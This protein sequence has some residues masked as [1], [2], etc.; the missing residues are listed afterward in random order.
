MISKLFTKSAPFLA[1]LGLAFTGCQPDLE[2]DIK[3]S[4]GTADFSRYIAVG[5]SL[6]A[7][8][9]DGGLYLEGQLT[10]YPNL[11]A[12]QFRSVGGGD[13]TQPLFTEAQRNGSGYI[14][15]TGFTTPAPPATPAPITAPVTSELA[16]RQGATAARPLYTK[17]TEP[18]SNLG[19][20]GIR[21]SDILTPGYGSVQGNP[22]FERITPDAQAT[23]TYLARVAASNPT[24]FTC[25]MGN[26][27]VLGFATAGAAGN[28][29]TPL[30][31][32]TNNNN[33]L[34]DALTAN[35]A[36]GLVATIPDVTNIPF[37]TTVGPSFRATLTTNNV[38]G[39]VITTGGFSS[40]PGTPPVRR[41]IA[42]TAIRDANGNGNQLF[43]LTAS[44]YLA[45]FGR[46]NNGRAWRD[47]Y[48]QARP[49]LPP[50]VTLS[51][52]LLLQ[53]VDTTQA[54]GASA[55]NPIPSTLVLDDTEQAQIRTATT[56][57]NTALTTKATAKNLA[58]FD[59]NG[60]FARVATNGF[61]TNGVNNSA[62][63]ITGNLFSLD[64]VHL[65]PRGYAVVA[66]EMI[67][68]INQQYGASVPNINPND[69]RGVRFP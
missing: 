32:F 34:I 8:F 5:N 61:V 19:V 50:T 39:V 3:P 55:G 54:F 31:T 17:F 66:N 26:N 42:T 64:G 41:T 13:F 35:N 65:T 47:V 18:V 1:L 56:N 4:S 23:Q 68:I 10:S 28:S 22:Y 63:F 60:F 67:R 25:W 57:F 43:T 37:F 44:P 15:L 6:T 58:V 40:T 7:G 51:V 49:S 21:M 36:K 48:N 45:L 20:P 69:Y 53:G 30:A 52:F 59:V 38:A 29:L 9:A 24:F 27:D 62:Q 16:L 33:Q 46:P 11:L 12:Q 2:E 14:R